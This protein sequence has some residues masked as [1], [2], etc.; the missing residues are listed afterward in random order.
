MPT[1]LPF[2]C[3]S[4]SLSLLL[5]LFH[6]LTLFFLST[7]HLQK[8]GV[9]QVVLLKT[10]D[11][12]C[13]TSS[14]LRRHQ[15]K[16]LP[17]ATGADQFECS[18]FG[19]SQTQLSPNPPLLSLSHFISSSLFHF[20]NFSFFS[21][22][23][24]KNPLKVVTVDLHA[25]QAITNFVGASKKGERTSKFAQLNKNGK[26]R[27]SLISILSSFLLLLLELI[28]DTFV[29]RLFLNKPQLAPIW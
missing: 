21:N 1:H 16:R 25:R 26:N 22:Y 15:H 3:L 9:Q 28:I 14:S 27:S 19:V 8:E 7:L 18:N 5:W 20:F 24:S 17:Q 13:S 2:H 10:L 23:K 29:A 11:L 4:L 12:F 6:S